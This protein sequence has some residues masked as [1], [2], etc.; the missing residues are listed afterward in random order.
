MMVSGA[1]GFINKTKPNEKPMVFKPAT[2]ERV[3]KIN[4]MTTGVAGFSAKTVGMIGKHAQNFAAGLSGHKNTQHKTLNADGTHN[5]NYKPGLLNKTL[6]AWSTIGDGISQSGKQLL[7]SSGA[8]AS[9]AVGH[10][11]GAEA[12]SLT[13]DLAGGVK[14]VGLVYIDVT[15]VTRRGIMKSVAKGMVVGKV[16]NKKGEEQTV[17]VGGGDGG[18]LTPG[19]AAKL[20]P[21]A[22]ATNTGMPSNV[23]SNSPSGQIGFGNQPPPSYRSGVGESLEGQPAYQGYPTEKR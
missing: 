15:G 7:T 18:S 12:G 5:E 10:K 19:T 14:N 4:T 11:W 2:H 16:K 6:I 22:N 1:E 3:R 21:M 20:D 13:G 8:A 23:S 9:A 17:M